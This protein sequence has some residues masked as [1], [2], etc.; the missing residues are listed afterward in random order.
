MLYTLLQLHAAA[1]IGLFN[2]PGCLFVL[3]ASL[4]LFKYLCGSICYG[5]TEAPCKSGGVASPAEWVR[6]E[7][8]GMACGTY[9]FLDLSCPFPLL[10]TYYIHERDVR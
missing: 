3:D 8:E 2:K 4:C 5:V 10:H 6:N 1:A 9:T 7:G